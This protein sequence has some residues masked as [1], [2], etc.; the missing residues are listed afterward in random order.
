MKT[1]KTISSIFVGNKEVSE[2]KKNNFEHSLYD[3]SAFEDEDELK[4]LTTGVN[5]K[6]VL[7]KSSTSCKI[8]DI[9]S[10]I[11]GGFSSRF[12]MLRKYFNSCKK[13][14]FNDKS[15]PFYSW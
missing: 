3:K 4:A 9:Q 12:W 1:F 15:V 11:Y 10:I 13:T 2:K 7:K 6:Y 14:E 8:K 5:K